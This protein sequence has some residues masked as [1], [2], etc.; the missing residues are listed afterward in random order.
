VDVRVDQIGEE[1]KIGF[2]CEIKPAMVEF[3]HV[4]RS[5]PGFLLSRR[6]GADAAREAMIVG[7]DRRDVG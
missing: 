3:A 5:S 7:A 1:L 6:R 4:V 2:S